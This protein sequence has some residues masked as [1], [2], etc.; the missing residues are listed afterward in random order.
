MLQYT[1]LDQVKRPFV[2][3]KDTFTSQI[4]LDPRQ[5]NINKRGMIIG[6]PRSGVGLMQEILKSLGITHVRINYDKN[7]IGDYRFL[8]DQ[9]RIN[10][11][12][13]YDSY[14]FPFTETYQWIT[15]GQFTHNHMKY[16]DSIYCLLRESDYIV[17]L[18]KRNLRSVVVSHALQKRND[19]VFFTDDQKM[20]EMYIE[21]P[22][23]KEVFENS[24]LILPW[25]ENN[26]FDVISFEDLTGSGS[27]DTQYQTIMKLME[28][29]GIKSV[30]IDTVISRSVK[31][32]KSEW[33]KYWSP[34]VE[35][36]F[37]N[38]GFQKMN[39]VLGY[40]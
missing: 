31:S 21:L 7:S 34:N 23:Y 39:T 37:N 12:R 11:S 32:Y 24:K 6:M 26:T 27:V 9:D 2:I 22:Y 36:W 18:L 29:Y 4:C 40:N 20:M 35:K 25:F 30:Q 5:S 8:T 15:K 10:F 17:H 16:D 3:Y 13:A 38:T 1:V 19:G 14:I 33:E 28:D